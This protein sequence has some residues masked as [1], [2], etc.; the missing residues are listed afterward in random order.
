M[1][2][3]VV[4]YSENLAQ[5]INMP[6]MLQGVFDVAVASQLFVPEAIKVRAMSFTEYHLA[7]QAQGFIHIQCKILSGRTPEQQQS[8]SRELF[9]YLGQYPL[10]AIS[11]TVEVLT[12][13]KASYQKRVT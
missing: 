3:F 12:M 11:L 5:K 10:E 9:D 1:P 4:E 6:N 13:D 8:L 2:H 7:D